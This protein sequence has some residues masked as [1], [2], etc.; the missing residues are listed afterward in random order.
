MEIFLIWLALAAGVGFLADSRGRNGFGFFLLSVVL[1]PL[2]GLVIVLVIKNIKED[3]A[4]EHQRK[5]DEESKERQRKEEHERQL[6]S[7]KVIASPKIV[8]PTGSIADEIRKLDALR[9]EG[10]LSDAEF[11]TQKSLILGLPPK[12]ES[13][14]TDQVVAA[15]VQIDPEP[16]EQGICPN[17]HATIP[18]SSIECPKCTASF[19]IGSS[20]KITPIS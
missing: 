14:Q 7:I 13:T 3:E 16:V 17:C 18:V 1:S 9:K 10:L 5:I 19:D 12:Q 11:D 4:K 20:W 8:A 15:P 2:L 6:E